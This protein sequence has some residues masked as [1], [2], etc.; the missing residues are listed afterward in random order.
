[1][2]SNQH[3]PQVSPNGLVNQ[4]RNTKRTS[5]ELPSFLGNYIP[6][7]QQESSQGYTSQLRAPWLAE[8]QLIWRQII[9]ILRSW[10]PRQILGLPLVLIAT[11]MLVL[12]WGEEIIFR[13]NVE[14]CA[15]G[16]W[17]NWVGS[18]LLSNERT[19]GG[20]SMF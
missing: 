16:R 8:W 6:V 11:W 13:R 9:G 14:S 20:R 19:L 17:E 18:S 1:M 4:A 2:T 3:A 5:E 10:R 12:W 7:T 15:W